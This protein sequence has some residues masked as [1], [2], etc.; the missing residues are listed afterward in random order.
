MPVPETPGVAPPD[1]AR[2]LSAIRRALLRHYDRHR[3]D[4]PW[5]GTADPYRVWV[6]EIMLQQTRAD[7]VAPYYERWLERFPTLDALADAELDDVLRAWQGLGYYARARNLHRAARV[8]RERHGGELP[9]DAAALRALPG[10]GAYTA[11]AIASIAFGEPCP[12]VDGNVRRVLARLFDLA[13]AAPGTLHDLAARLVPRRRAGDFNQAM[14]DLGAT[15]CSPR[16]PACGECP[17]ARWCLARA[18]GTQAERPARR[19]RP[20]VPLYD[21]GT[22]VLRARDGR[23]LLVRRPEDGLLGGMWS[24]PGEVARAGESVEDAAARAGRAASGLATVGRGRPRGSVVHVFSHRREVYHVFVFE[25]A[26]TGAEGTAPCRERVAPCRERVALERVALRDEGVALRDEG[27]VRGD[28]GGRRVTRRRGARG[29]W[30][31]PG[32]LER[33]ALPAAQRR[34]L[35]MLEAG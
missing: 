3:R 9:R 34:I 16:R 24:F 27:V 14:M 30:V 25:V 32:E 7:V 31:A 19:R 10:V 8:V 29:V 15:L 2:R 1:D 35:G 6:S 26:A 4:L 13:D 18:R 21:V 12:A 20:E 23:L 11:G 28:Q 33:Y 5:R 22:A 17:L